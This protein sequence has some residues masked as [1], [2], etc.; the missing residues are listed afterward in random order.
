VSDTD[1]KKTKRLLEMYRLSAFSHAALCYNLAKEV[2]HTTL[3]S[4]IDAF[5]RLNYSDRVTS[6]TVIHVGKHTDPE[7][8]LKKVISNVNRLTGIL[9]S[10][11]RSKRVVILENSAGQGWRKAGQNRELG[12]TIEELETIYNGVEKKEQLYFC[13]D[14][15]HLFARGEWPIHEP[16]GF[17]R[18]LSAFDDRIGIDRIACIH[19]NDSRTVYGSQVDRHAPLG[20]GEIFRD[21]RVLKDMIDLLTHRR[22]PM[23]SETGSGYHEKTLI[24]MLREDF[25]ESSVADTRCSLR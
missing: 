2:P 8:G 10:H 20:L 5:S 9:S 22:I 3:I 13:I 12:S 17:D 4:E 16:M 14:T 15:Q 23:I 11:D 19:L 25:F 1:V 6:G 24:R 21:P 18:F 7:T